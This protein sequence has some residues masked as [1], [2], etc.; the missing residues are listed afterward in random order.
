MSYCLPTPALCD[1]PHSQSPGTN[2]FRVSAGLLNIRAVRILPPELSCWSSCFCYSTQLKVV[3]FSLSVVMMSTAVSV[4]SVCSD[5]K[6]RRETGRNRWHGGG[7]EQIV[8]LSRFQYWSLV[9]LA[10]LRE[11]DLIFGQKERTLDPSPDPTVSGSQIQ[12]SLAPSPSTITPS[13]VKLWPPILGDFVAGSE[14]AE[15]QMSSAPAAEAPM[16]SACGSFQDLTLQRSPFPVDGGG[17]THTN[18]L[19][20]RSVTA[21]Y[22]REEET[23]QL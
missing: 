4:T 23:V 3:W 18:A 14:T 19:F 16:T 20:C 12:L 6:E 21:H 13:A 8:S 10:I 5:V 11:Y 15:L 22:V 1:D 7:R 9:L 2:F 17:F